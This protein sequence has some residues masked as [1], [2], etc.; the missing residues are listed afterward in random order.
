[1]R[2]NDNGS[3]RNDDVLEQHTPDI[4]ILVVVDVVETVG[5]GN[6]RFFLVNFG[7]ELVRTDE[8][9]NLLV[10]ALRFVFSF[11]G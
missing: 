8:A 7:C 6:R 2:C 1:M 9:K 4:G 3:D 11:L 10:E 5:K